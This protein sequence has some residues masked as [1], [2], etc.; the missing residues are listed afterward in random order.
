MRV[1]ANQELLSDDS[2]V[3]FQR[4]LQ[5]HRR[6]QLSTAV[7]RILSRIDG[8]QRNQQRHRI[9]RHARPSKPSPQPTSTAPLPVDC[10]S[11]INL[12][13]LFRRR[14]A[15][16]AR[17]QVA[18]HQRSRFGGQRAPKALAESAHAHQRRHSHR[19]RQHNERKLAR[20]GLQIAPADRC[21]A[22]PA[23]R[24]PSHCSSS[25]W[26]EVLCALNKR[27]RVFHHHA[28]L[29]HD[30]AIRAARH[31]GVV[32]HQ[33]QRGAALRCCASAADPAPAGRWSSRDFLSARPPSRSADRPQTPAP[34]Q[35]AAAR[36]RRVESDSAPSARPVPPARAAPR[37][38]SSPLPF[39]IQLKRQQHILKRRERRNQLI[40]LKDKSDLLPAHRCQLGLGQIVN[41][42]SIQPDLALAWRVESRQQPQQRALAAAARAHNGH[43]LPRRNA[44]RNALQNFHAPRP[45]LNPLLH[46]PDLDHRSSLIAA[47]SSCASH[48]VCLYEPR[49]FARLHC[50]VDVRRRSL[51]SLLLLVLAAPLLAAAAPGARLLRRQHHRRLRPGTASRPIPM[52]CSAISTTSATTTSSSIAAPAAPPPRTPSP[53]P[54]HPRLHPAVVIVEFGGNDGLRGLPLD[55]TRRNLDTVIS[56]LQR[57]HI[58]VLSPASLCRPTT[59]PTTFAS[60]I[61]SFSTS[62]PSHRTAFVPMIYK[63]LVNVSRHHP[64]R[65]NPPHRQRLRDHRQH[66][67][68]RAQALLQK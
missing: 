8:L 37:A 58:K 22:A 50:S 26:N 29:Q 31:F 24:A 16:D 14:L 49:P 5:V 25:L 60:S 6:L 39:N 47:L 30:L 13:L 36:R 64:A 35:R 23:Q 59:A 28:V 45:V 11:C 41:R 43:K 17:A 68:A 20:R 32:R 40:R 42:R 46:I 4:L 34:A 15:I 38:R 48:C 2:R 12:L 55:Q 54:F 61:R 19:N 33:H 65:W 52:P 62:P 1:Q 27:Q 53:A 66:A 44:Q 9:G 63:D 56:A 18:G 3:A 67:T 57:A 7:I 21:R 10:A 51:V